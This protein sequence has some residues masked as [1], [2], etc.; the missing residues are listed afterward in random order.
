MIMIAC[1]FG[2]LPAFLLPAASGGRTVEAVIFMLA[3]FL[4]RFG[5]ATANVLMITLRQTVTPARLLGRMN[6]AS[7]TVVYTLGPLGGIV[8]GVLG[9]TIG[10]R[11]T[12]WVAAVGFALTLTPLLL[13]PIPSLKVLP[14]PAE[15]TAA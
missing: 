8:G 12:L 4:I 10:L 6:V 9:A 13:S 14:P 3:F 1:C 7:R 5:L 11:N 15:D 2:T